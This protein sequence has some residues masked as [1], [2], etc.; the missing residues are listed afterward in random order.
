[1]VNYHQK[2]DKGKLPL[3]CGNGER[4]ISIYSLPGN[5][6]WVQASTKTHTLA[7]TTVQAY[8]LEPTAHTLTLIQNPTPH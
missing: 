8:L 3:S 2:R 5:P 6:I 1:M 4:L 7:S